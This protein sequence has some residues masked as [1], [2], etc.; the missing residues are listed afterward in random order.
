LR[1]VPPVTADDYLKILRAIRSNEKAVMQEIDE[2]T[3]PEPKTNN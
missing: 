2:K 1:K 3:T